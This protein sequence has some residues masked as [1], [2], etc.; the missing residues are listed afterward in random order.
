[1]GAIDRKQRQHRLLEAGGHDDRRQQQPG[2]RHEP[3]HRNP[4]PGF[5]DF[6]QPRQHQR[7]AGTTEDES[8]NADQEWR[9]AF[10]ADGKQAERTGGKAG[11]NDRRI[12]AHDATAPRR[13][14][15]CDHPDLTKN[16][17]RVG[18]HADQEAQRKPQIDVLRPADQRQ[19]ECGKCCAGQRRA[20]C[21]EPPCQARYQWRRQDE[22]DRRH[23]RRKPD[24]G[25]RDALALQDEA[26]Q[27]IGKPLRDGE[28]RNGRDHARDRRP[29][30]R[31][32]S[33]SFRQIHVGSLSG[34][35]EWS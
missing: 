27:R 21:P 26:Q 16:I 5:V 33:A 32:V 28:H 10:G 9:P 17:E 18:D 19:H 2:Q 24:H 3:H 12:D 15:K 22:A 25:R 1:M 4:V 35:P 31:L 11:R 7:Q 30:H 14:G 6:R 29:L 20:P 34:S 13:W 8:A 23:R